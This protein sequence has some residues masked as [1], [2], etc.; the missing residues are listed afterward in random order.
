LLRR[1]HAAPAFLNTTQ[2]NY[3][4]PMEAKYVRRLSILPSDGPAKN[5]FAKQR[6][7]VM[8]VELLVKTFDPLV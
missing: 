2:L 5:R 1:I 4:I 7:G 8:V 3:V 6:D